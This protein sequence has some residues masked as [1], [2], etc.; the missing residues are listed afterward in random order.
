MTRPNFLFI[1]PDKTGSSWMFHI[2]TRHPDCFVPVAKDIYFF[3]RYYARGMNWYLRHFAPARPGATAVGELSHDYLFSPDAAERV[4]RDL[5]DAKIVL[6]LR[7]PVER[8]VSQ[9]QYLR[10]GG[11]A[12]GDFL[13]AVRRTPRIVDN[14]RYL[15]PV[16]HWLSLFPREQVKILI[17]EDLRADPRA[18]GEDLLRFLGLRTDVDLPYSDRVREAGMARNRLLARILKAGA[19]AARGLGLAN[20]VG[21]VKHGATA[22]LAYREMRPEERVQLTAAQKLALWQIFADERPG[23]ERITGRDLSHWVPRAEQ[24]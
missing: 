19:M 21:R 8:S 3:D 23:L 4:R 24:G 10:R 7:N 2:L 5:P 17:F 9:F 6:C 14:S 22:Q 11:E 15:A 1:G 12:D 18:F 13:A 20:L 16:E